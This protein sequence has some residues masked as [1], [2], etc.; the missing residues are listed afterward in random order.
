LNSF[1]CIRVEPG[2]ITVQRWTWSPELKTFSGE[3]VER[4]AK[5]AD[6][7]EPGADVGFRMSDFG[8]GRSKE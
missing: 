4:Y 6:G 3:A 2:F 5:T 1:N 7:W 8:G